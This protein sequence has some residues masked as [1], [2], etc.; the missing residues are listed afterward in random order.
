MTLRDYAVP[1]AV[2]AL[3]DA[4]ETTFVK[5]YGV[6]QA[7]SP[8][9]VDATTRFQLAS[10]SK[11]I[12]ATSIATLV[13]RGVVSWDVPVRQF[14][15]DTVLAQPYATENASLRDYL[16]H[17]T[18]LPA[19]AGDLLPQLRLGCHG[20][21]ASRPLPAVRSQLSIAMGLFELRHFPRAAERGSCGW[22]ECT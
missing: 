13:D 19:Y 6:R 9:L 7:G 18:G 5:G 4:S 3:A 17:R 21:G 2:V 14:S 1:G 11:F 12:A 10:L 22:T 16:A 15:P 20:A 8:A